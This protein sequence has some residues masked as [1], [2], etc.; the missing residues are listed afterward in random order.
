MFS[1]CL[2]RVIRFGFWRACCGC[3]VLAP[4]VKLC[5]YCYAPLKVFEV[6][7]HVKACAVIRAGLS[8]R[9]AK[10]PVKS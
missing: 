6:K 1:M 7:R 8:T 3:R 10:E 4:S 9:S 2:A 5:P